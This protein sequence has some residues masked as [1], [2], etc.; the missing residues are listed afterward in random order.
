MNKL[1]LTKEETKKLEER[2][3][4]LVDRDDFTILVERIEIL[5]QYIYKMSIISPYEV[6]LFKE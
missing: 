1:V 3:A 4:V 6:E 5:G 2:N